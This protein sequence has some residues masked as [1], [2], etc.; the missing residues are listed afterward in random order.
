[1]QELVPQLRKGYPAI[2]ITG[3]R[4]SG[5]T[6]LARA[7][8]PDLPYVNFE[9]PLERA[10]FEADPLGFL[11]RFPEG[12]IFD[13]VQHVPDLLSY[14]QVRIDAER[15][16]GRYILTGSQQL[17]L[18]RGVSQS[19]AG[20]VALLELLPMSHAELQAA[21]QA[22]RSLAD[23]VFRGSYPVLYDHTREVTPTRWLEDYLNTVINRDVRQ[24][25][26]VRNRR[27]FDRFVRLCAA[28]TG[29]I[30][31]ASSLAEECDVSH[32]TIQS[33]VSVLEACYLVRLLKPYYRNFGKRL[34]KSPKLYFI[35]S[36]L[37]C[38]LLHIAD[39]NQLT[40]HPLW[41]A[42]AETWCIGEAIKARLNRG[43]PPAAWYWRSS[44]GIEVDL[45]FE[46]GSGLVPMEIKS[47]ATP[48][49]R[50]LKALKKFRTLSEREPL[51]NVGPGVVVYGG[52]EA[53]SS[54]AD[55]FIPWH[56]IAN[57]VPV[58]P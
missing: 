30:F 55:R 16:V 28:R 47:A 42:L 5:K 56:A 9:S 15:S 1:M 20:R 34:V 6:T 14:L 44:D 32:M 2:A 18:G 49:Q 45:L 29:Q 25:I 19:L 7:A 41:G 8:C 52:E 10:D 12:G 43:V 51:V 3:P 11:N 26:E 54:G 13:E 57:E 24:I 33:W 39:I 50:F 36:G 38:R 40:L 31:N 22:P 58:Q 17:E 37:A 21:G 48:Q 53:R 27:G 4:Q 46:L 35:D 23:A